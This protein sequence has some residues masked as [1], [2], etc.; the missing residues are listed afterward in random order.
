M[1]SRR[2]V[3][4]GTASLGTLVA[5]GGAA[6]DEEL[7]AGLHSRLERIESAFRT[8]DAGSLRGSFSGSGK[9]R[10]DLKGLTPGRGS[11]GPGQLQVIFAAIFDE[12][13][14]REFRF[15]RDDVQVSTPGT[16]FAKGRWVRRS[17]RGS[18]D[19]ETLCFTLREE[20]GD[21]RV[22]EIRSSP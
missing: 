18:Q 6:P 22:L 10:V 7:A 21:W 14:T 19:T 9:V 13:R 12:Y 17:Q 15:G 20:D 1:M 3:L 16:A 2:S 8:G 11:Y 4:I 5:A